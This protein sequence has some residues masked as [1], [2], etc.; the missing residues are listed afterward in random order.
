[1]LDRP[2]RHGQV[3]AIFLLAFLALVACAQESIAQE[4]SRRYWLESFDASIQVHED[5]AIEVTERLT[6]RFDGGFNGIYRDIAVEFETPW[7]LDYDL[8][9]SPLSVT[10]GHGAALRNETHRRGGEFRFKVWIPDARDASRTVVLRYSVRRAL[11]FPEA[12]EGFDAHDQLYWNVTGDRWTV[13]ILSASVRVVL[14]EAVAG[15]P[16]VR[17]LVGPYGGGDDRVRIERPAHNEVLVRAGRKLEPGEGLTIVVGW[18]PGTVRRPTLAERASELLADNWPLATPVA[19]FLLMLAVFWRRGRDPSLDRSIMV[20]Y[21]PPEGMLPAEVGTLIDEKV[22]LRDIVATVIDLAVRGYLRI[23]E[24]V[25]EGW[26]FDSTATTFVRLKQADSSLRPYES[27]ILEGLFERADEV[28]MED[29]ETRFYKRISEIKS[30]L[31]D[32]LTEQRLFR[33]RPDRVRIFWFVVAALVLPIWIT[34]GL[35]LGQ[36]AFLIAAP[37][38][39]LA[40]GVFAAFMPARTAVGRARFLDVKGFEEFLGRT[41]AERFK[42]LDLPATTFEEYL[43][44]AMALGVADQWAKLFSGLLHQPPSWYAGPT[45]QFHSGLF[46]R[47]MGAMGAA[48]GTAMTTAPRS[49][50]GSSGFSA[51]GGF[52]GGGFGGGGGGAF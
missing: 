31:Y 10:D 4:A 36:P 50:S 18:T 1:M 5:G 20:R 45:G 34:L 48:L 44:Y 19:V 52:S 33:A 7:G 47:R 51:G 22:D 43:P 14:P 30:E 25:R 26:L 28:T 15:E 17:G 32:R 11:R 37:F 21:E 41:E 13:P 8:R 38:T 16:W 2:Y 12:A 29:L 42:T 3:T 6:F 35:A 49:S 40:V 24:S 23:E 9:L 39:S 46:T 27:K